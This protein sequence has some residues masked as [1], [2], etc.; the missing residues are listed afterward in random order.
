M[1]AVNC[2]L[3]HEN[4]IIDDLQFLVLEKLRMLLGANVLNNAVDLLNKQFNHFAE[5]AG[6]FWQ[7]QAD[8]K[9]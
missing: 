7:I 4:F 8:V 6:R 5:A 9:V 2:V 3:D 1:E